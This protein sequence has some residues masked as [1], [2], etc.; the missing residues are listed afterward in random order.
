MAK[1]ALITAAGSGMGV[2]SA[3]SLRVNVGR[4]CRSNLLRTKDSQT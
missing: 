2:R 1:V 3:H 4:P